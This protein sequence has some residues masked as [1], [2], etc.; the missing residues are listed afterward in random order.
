M[1]PLDETAAAAVAEQ[2]TSDPRLL[3]AWT[4]IVAAIYGGITA[5]AVVQPTALE[6]PQ[7]AGPVTGTGTIT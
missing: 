6:A 5:N 4:Q 7:D 1:P 2:I 3:P